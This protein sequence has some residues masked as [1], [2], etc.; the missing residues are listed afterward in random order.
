MPPDCINYNNPSVAYGSTLVPCPDVECP[1]ESPSS[2]L[3]G[4]SGFYQPNQD[5]ALV[6]FGCLPPKTDYVGIQTVLYEK[7]KSNVRDDLDCRDALSSPTGKHVKVFPPAP[8]VPGSRVVV[9]IP[10]YDTRNHLSL[11]AVGKPGSRT[12]FRSLFVHVTNANKQV[13]RDITG[14]PSKA[15]NVDSIPNLPEFHLEGNSTVHDSFRTIYRVVLPKSVVSS[16]G[17]LPSSSTDEM[18]KYI[19][20]EHMNILVRYLTPKVPIRKNGLLLKSQPRGLWDRKRLTLLGDVRSW[21]CC[22]P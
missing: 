2:F 12:K 3:P 13:A 8:T 4:K 21:R 14:V 20:F 9:D 22:Q 18:N 17:D 16:S 7:A 19:A 15:I 11:N 6:L 1:P 5:H 10:W